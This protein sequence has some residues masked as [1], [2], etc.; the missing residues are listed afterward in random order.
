MRKRYIVFFVQDKNWI[1]LFLYK[2]KIGEMKIIKK[3]EIDK[4]EKIK[5]LKN[6]R[7]R[8]NRI[9]IYS[10]NQKRKYWSI[11]VN[12]NYTRCDLLKR[13]KW[14]FLKIQDFEKYN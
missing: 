3:I 7:S 10:K 5:I 9:W 4:N 13:R 12:E 2:Y 1:V 6:A 8:G 14:K 11:R